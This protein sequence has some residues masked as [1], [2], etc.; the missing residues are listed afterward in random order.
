MK[1][2]FMGTPE[3]AV[4]SLLRLHSSGHEISLVVTQM[5]RAKGRGKK[6]AF[7]P[8][9]EAALELGLN[10]FQPD[11]INTEES[12]LRLQEEN[13][14]LFVVVAYG[15]L[16]KPRIFE[17]PKY[18][19][20]NVHGSLL[21]KY[22]GA[23]PIQSAVMCG[24]QEIG[25]T[26]MQIQEGLDAGDILSQ[27]SIEL[28]DMDSEEAFATLSEVGADLLCDTVRDFDDFFNNRKKQVEEDATITKKITKNMGLIDWSS[29][30]VSIHNSVRGLKP[31]PIAYTKYRGEVMKI[32]KTSVS[33]LSSNQ[34]CG[35]IIQISPK[36]FFVST[37]K[38]VLEIL[39]IQMPNKRKMTVSE[40][41]AGNSFELGAVLGGDEKD[42]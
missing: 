20:I 23:S 39:E 25:V 13:A 28:K 1:I 30:A 7:S 10:V 21:P 37:G 4:P 27:R 34:P 18:T 24:E 19:T 33:S 40:Y 22:R 9:K 26:I 14:D 2:V 36:S 15:Q 42:V 35:R 12:F 3:F 32:H 17:M 38:G 11:S 29:D 6:I 41:L 16:I 31:W 5:D 8:V